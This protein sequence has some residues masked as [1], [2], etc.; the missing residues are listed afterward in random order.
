[1]RP[2]NETERNKRCARCGAVLRHIDGSDPTT[3]LYSNDGV[4]G[5]VERTVLIGGYREGFDG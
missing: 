5:T 1:M 2:K 3:V 4:P